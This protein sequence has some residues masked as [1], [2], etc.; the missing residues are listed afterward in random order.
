MESLKLYRV[1]FIE[2]EGTF[3]I[4]KSNKASVFIP[5]EEIAKMGESV[6]NFVKL[7]EETPFAF[8]LSNSEDPS[9]EYQISKDISLALNKNAYLC[10]FDPSPLL[11]SLLL[12]N[13]LSKLKVYFNKHAQLPEG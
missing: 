3:G 5:K 8:T 4:T 2:T 1:A 10:Y 6:L 9:Q 13:Y 12:K 7:E 11:P